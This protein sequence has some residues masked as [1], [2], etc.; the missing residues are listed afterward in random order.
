M[1]GKVVGL[2]VLSNESAYLM[3]HTKLI[4]SYAVDAELKRSQPAAQA[5]TTSPQEF[6]ASAL[7][8][9]ES[10]FQSPGVGHD[11]RFEAPEISGS[12]LVY[13]STVIHLAFLSGEDSDRKG[14][15]RRRWSRL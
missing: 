5:S 13:Q 12:A 7:G 2:E 1:N 6:L 15:T 8:S 10:R 11:Y 9:T 4:K 14:E 3:L